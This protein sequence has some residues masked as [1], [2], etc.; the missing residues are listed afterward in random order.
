M[1][2]LGPGER[3]TVRREQQYAYLPRPA[4]APGSKRGVNIN[5]R[6]DLQ[7]MRNDREVFE[8]SHREE[9][10]RPLK[11]WLPLKAAR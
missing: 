4:V 6:P 9:T 3:T 2:C 8:F 1:D 10:F 5:K 7:V 11:Y